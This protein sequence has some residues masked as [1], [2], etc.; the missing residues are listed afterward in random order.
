MKAKSIAIHKRRN[1]K[2]IQPKSA[3]ENVKSFYIL[4]KIFNYL[5][6]NKQFEIIK[7]NKKI[8]NR[9][10]ITIDNYKKYREMFSQIEIE[11]IAIKNKDC[12]FINITEYE[13]PYY[14]IYFND[15]KEEIKKYSLNKN[16]KVSKINIKIDYQIESFYGLFYQCRCIESI[17]FKKFYRN[18]IKNMNFMFQWCVSLEKVNLSNFN[19]D[20]VTDMSGMFYECHSLIEVDLSKFNIGTVKDMRYMFFGCHSLEN[21]ILFDIT[22]IDHPRMEDMFNGCSI[23]FKEKLKSEKMIF[24]YLYSYFI[25][26]IEYY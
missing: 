24:Y 18:N 15:N 5:M 20:N 8:Q 17:S 6:K 4:K 10:N 12:K 26:N 9:L 21:L 1:I 11:V 14:H 2:R 22:T 16:D 7:Y 3:L 25:S 13:K 19:T 23:S